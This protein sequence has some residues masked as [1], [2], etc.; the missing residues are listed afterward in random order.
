MNEADGKP[1]EIEKQERLCWLV[2]DSLLLSSAEKLALLDGLNGLRD[3]RQ[4]Q[5]LEILL[6][7]KRVLEHLRR[8]AFESEARR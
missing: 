1:T 5:L 7:E 6:D 3:A 4:C 8:K 2:E